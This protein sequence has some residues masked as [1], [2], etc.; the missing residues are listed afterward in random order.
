MIVMATSGFHSIS[1]VMW[2][3]RFD[4]LV[5]EARSMLANSSG[6]VASLG[7]AYFPSAITLMT[8]SSAVSS[9]TGA[10]VDWLKYL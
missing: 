4:S 10:T 6:P 3:V 7:V 9:T 1:T 8:S 5:G 2:V